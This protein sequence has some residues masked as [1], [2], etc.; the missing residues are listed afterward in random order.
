MQINFIMKNSYLKCSQKSYHVCGGHVLVPRQISSFFLSIRRLVVGAGRVGDVFIVSMEA[1]GDLV[2]GHHKHPGF[3]ILVG[4]YIR[5]SVKLFGDF[6]LM[7]KAVNSL[8][9]FN[10][11]FF[12]CLHLIVGNIFK[13]FI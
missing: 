12:C 1:D 6:L 3:H 9:E 4:V 7:R 2:V 10:Y 13:I 11:F 8:F 5:V